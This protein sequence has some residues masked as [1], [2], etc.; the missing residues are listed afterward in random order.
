MFSMHRTVAGE[1]SV[2]EKEIERMKESDRDR[3]LC[4]LAKRKY[5]SRLSVDSLGRIIPFECTKW[6][7]NMLVSW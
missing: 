5:A 2:R 3:R 6:V 4:C 1:K 7:D